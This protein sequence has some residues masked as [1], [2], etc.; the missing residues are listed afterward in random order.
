M[1]IF[2]TVC[3]QFTSK[4]D[5]ANIT[6]YCHPLLIGTTTV[7]SCGRT[8]G[9]EGGAASGGTPQVEGYALGIPQDDCA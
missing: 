5:R 6:S 1:S 9:V 8:G 7:S 2:S 3:E 4:C